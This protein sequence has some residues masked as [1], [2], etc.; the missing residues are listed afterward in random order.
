MSGEQP[1]VCEHGIR[2][3][4]HCDPCD[5]AAWEAHRAA[6]AIE[7]RRAETLGSVHEG[8]GPK[9]IAQP[10]SGDTPNDMAR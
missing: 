6:S 3:P 10:L 8:A 2:W 1:K 9:D 7:T 5:G 4:W